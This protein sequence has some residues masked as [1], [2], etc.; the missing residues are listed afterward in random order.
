MRTLT[1]PRTG[2]IAFSVFSAAL[3]GSCGVVTL[4]AE[5]EGGSGLASSRAVSSATATSASSGESGGT[6]DSADEE[7]ARK[8]LA[9]LTVAADG[10]MDGYD[11][12]R[13][14]HWSEQGDN[15]NTREVVL[16][17]DGTGVEVDEECRP[18]S[19][20]WTSPYDGD[21]WTDPSD[22][23]IDHVV[24][25]AEAWRSGADTWTDE[26]RE[27]FANDL[28]GVNLLAVTDNVNQAKGDKAPEEWQP[29]LESYRC[30]Y[31]IH[32]IDVK[33]TWKLTVEKDEK[34]TLEEMLDRC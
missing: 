29:P 20:S 24:P 15:C 11:R 19:G 31:A 7:T 3:L 9:E 6:G 26:R 18:T 23:D 13:F 12:D 5:G 2:L 28:D 10:G 30:T 32:W 33:H 16:K 34:A 27:E 22:V 4:E 17:R 21:T 8:Q 1:T 25:L 14:P